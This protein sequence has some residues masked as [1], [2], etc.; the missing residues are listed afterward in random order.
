MDLLS[1]QA[2][3][4]S[5]NMAHSSDFGARAEVAI[6]AWFLVRRFTKP[7]SQAVEKLVVAHETNS[8][9]LS[10]HSKQLD[11]HEGRLD[12]HEKRIVVLEIDKQIKGE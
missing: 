11:E 10:E 5:I 3:A 9:R 8:L 2:L 6:F 12:S 4:E 1:V 7:I